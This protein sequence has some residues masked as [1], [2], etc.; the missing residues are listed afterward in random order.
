M[1]VKKQIPSFCK[2]Y[3]FYQEIPVEFLDEIDVDSCFYHNFFDI[4]QSQHRIV[5]ASRGSNKK[6]IAIK[7]LQF[8]HI[9]TQQCYILQEE[10]NISEKELTYLVDSLRDFLKIFDHDSKSTQIPLPKPKVEIGATKSKDNL[11]AHYYNG[12]IEQPNRQFRLS[13][14]FGNNNSCVFFIAKFETHGNKFILTEFVNL[15]HREI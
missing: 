7:L 8:C 6:S 1:S 12:I 10:V 15:S 2:L 13:F 11:S 4:S 5:R 14:R 3:S 9:K